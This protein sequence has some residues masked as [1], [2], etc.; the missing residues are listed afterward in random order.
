MSE[1]GLGFQRREIGVDFLI[2]G[3][4]P[5]EERGSTFS[6]S[7]EKYN[8]GAATFRFHLP[9]MRSSHF[10]GTGPR[11]SAGSFHDFLLHLA[12]GFEEGLVF[13]AAAH[14]NAEKIGTEVVEGL[15]VTDQDPP[16]DQRLPEF[17]GG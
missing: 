7:R 13:P 4:P 1:L 14:G 6:T 9:T 3:D 2:A 16:G 8:S 17:G 10:S 11:P 12:Q 15:A 5:P